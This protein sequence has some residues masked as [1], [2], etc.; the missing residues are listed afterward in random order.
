MRCAAAAAATDT[1]VERAR[2]AARPGAAT[3][4][5]MFCVPPTIEPSK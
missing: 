1:P 3:A 4:P 5:L 2:S